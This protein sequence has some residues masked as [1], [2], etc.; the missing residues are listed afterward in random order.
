MKEKNIIIDANL[1]VDNE[2]KQKSIEKIIEILK[3]NE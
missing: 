1:I 3:I 2:Y